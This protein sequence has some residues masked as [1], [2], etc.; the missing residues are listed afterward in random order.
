MGVLSGK[1]AEKLHVNLLRSILK[2]SHTT[3]TAI[4]LAESDRLPLS[5]TWWKQVLTFH[6]RMVKLASD[7]KTQDR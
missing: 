3:C 1:E 4:V 7:P 6:D 2:V 5:Y